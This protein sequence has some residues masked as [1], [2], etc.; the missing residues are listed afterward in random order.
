[1]DEAL[2]DHEPGSKHSIQAANQIFNTGSGKK[3]FITAIRYQFK[4]FQCFEIPGVSMQAAAVFSYF[5]DVRD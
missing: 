4:A 1:M 3:S 2:I 5:R